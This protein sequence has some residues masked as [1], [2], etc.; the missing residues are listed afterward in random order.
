MPRTTVEFE[1]TGWEPADANEHP[2]GLVLG[3][4][5]VRKVFRGE[6][7]ATSVTD[8]LTVGR[9][10]DGL[11]YTA[12]ERVEGTFAGR[13]G[14]FVVVHGAAEPKPP[15]LG[16]IGAGAGTGDLATLRGTVEIEHDDRGARFTF[17][18]EMD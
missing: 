13:S 14:T 2:D 16:T 12:I 15:A 11:A 7:E 10:D 1:V 9:G 17:D 18:Y 5:V 8:L 4:A 3:R 6:L